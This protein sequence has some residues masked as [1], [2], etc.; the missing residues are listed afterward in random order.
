M[1]IYEVEFELKSGRLSDLIDFVKPWIQRYQLW[2]DVRSKSERGYA[3]LNNKTDLPVQHQTTL[4]LA[5]KD[6]IHHILQ[7]LSA[8]V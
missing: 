7:K 6:D 8:T 4:E 1:D 5:A 2:L 3:L